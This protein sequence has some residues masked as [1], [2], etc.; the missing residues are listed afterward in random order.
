M[1]GKRSMVLVGIRAT[2]LLGLLGTDAGSTLTRAPVLSASG[3]QQRPDVARTASF[4]LQCSANGQPISPL[5][6]GVGGAGVS[7]WTTWTTAR[8]WGGNPTTRK[9][10]AQHVEFDQGRFRNTV[11]SSY[12]KFLD[13]NR[14]Y[15]VKSAL[16]VPM[17]GWV[18]KHTTSYSFPVAAFGPQQ[19][20][21]PDVPDSGNGVR[22]DGKPIVPGPPT[23]TSVAASP[24]YV[25]RWIREVRKQEGARGRT[26]DSYILDNEPMLWNS[27]HRDVHPEPTGYD[28]LLEKTIAYASRAARRSR[29]KDCR[30]CGWGWLAYHYSAKDVAAGVQLRPTAALTAT[31]R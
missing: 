9:L 19:A 15:G 30:S 25:E 3:I 4:V 28:E 22:R 10:A 8:R 7:A 23:V 5:I 29:R 20:T 6:Y 14:E 31:N 13:E 18:A 11:A 17:I 12:E 16:T 24:A 21:G 1:H 2:V 27:T 26:V